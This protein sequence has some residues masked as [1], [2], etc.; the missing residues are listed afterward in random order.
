[1]HTINWIFIFKMCVHPGL[2]KQKKLMSWSA[3]VIKFSFLIF[4]P[5]NLVKYIG[6]HFFD[7]NEKEKQEA[8]NSKNKWKRIF[9]S[10]ILKATL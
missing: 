10:F 4:S 1:M 3:E 9:H 6:K 2:E 8:K 7:Y 5:R